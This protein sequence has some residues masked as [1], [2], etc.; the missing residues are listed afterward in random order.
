MDETLE[1]ENPP[2]EVNVSN[3]GGIRL[4]LR[5]RDLMKKRKAEAEEK[6]TNQWVSGEQSLKRAKNW[7]S[8]TPGRKGRPR[9]QQLEV[10]SEDLSV[11]QETDPPSITPPV[12]PTEAITATP[13]PAEPQTAPVP[14]SVE[15]QKEKTLET[16]FIEDLGPDEEED[17]ALSQKRLVIDSEIGEQRTDVPEQIQISMP[18]FAP[19]TAPSYP[20]SLHENV[21]EHLI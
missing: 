6:S 10:L 15:K 19:A 12:L 2:S 5:D 11:V 13:Q 7:S 21:P 1:K 8:S 9:K 3:E 4:R 20:E 14:L 16:F 18:V 17:M